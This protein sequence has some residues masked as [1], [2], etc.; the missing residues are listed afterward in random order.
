MSDAAI[1]KSRILQTGRRDPVGVRY[2]IQKLRGEKKDMRPR[3]R[4][5]AARELRKRLYG[6]RTPMKHETDRLLTAI[7]TGMTA[8]QIVGANIVTIGK[9][10]EHAIKHRWDSYIRRGFDLPVGKNLRKR[11]EK[12][13]QKWDEKK[14]D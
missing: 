6:P 12:E 14:S 7:R 13:G 1:A 8:Q 10:T 5:A 3:T 4:E 2:R 11:V 9:N